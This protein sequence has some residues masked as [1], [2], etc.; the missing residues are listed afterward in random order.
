MGFGVSICSLTIGEDGPA[1][2]RLPEFWEDFLEEAVPE[3]WEGVGF[4]AWTTGG[5]VLWLEARHGGLD[6]EA[7][8]L[9]APESQC[10]HL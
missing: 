10:A 7:E 9:Y 6:P 4:R 8:W 1:E 5:T 2:W 3:D